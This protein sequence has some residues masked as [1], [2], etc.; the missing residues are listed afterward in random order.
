M[1]VEFITG[2]GIVS[3]YLPG[4]TIEMR[5]RFSSKVIGSLKQTQNLCYFIYLIIP[6]SLCIISIIEKKKSKC[7]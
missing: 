7:F 2:G 6:F 5:E 4:L 3:V 1:E